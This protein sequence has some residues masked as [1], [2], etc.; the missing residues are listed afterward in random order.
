MKTTFNDEWKIWIQTNLSNGQDKDYIFNLLIDEGYSYNA[1]KKEMKF[2]PIPKDEF[3]E[4]WL[5][6]IELNI[7]DGQNKNGLFKVLLTHGYSYDAIREVMQ[8]E[9]TV[10]LDELADP[11]RAG[12]QNLSTSNI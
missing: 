12:A 2:E 3:S 8:Y 5:D 9:P 7:A 11:F 6:W 4:E 10:P 1:V